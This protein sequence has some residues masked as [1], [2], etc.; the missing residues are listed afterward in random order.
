MSKL[1]KMSKGRNNNLDIIRLLAALGVIYSHAYPLCVGNYT[2][3]LAATLTRNRMSVG[4]IA[5]STFFILSGFLITK[6]FER[7]PHL[8]SYLKAR[9]FRIVPP[10]LIVILI[11]AFIIGPLCTSLPYKEYFRHTATWNYIKNL[12]MKFEYG[13]LPGV[14]ESHHNQGI[15]SSLWTLTYEVAFYIFIAIIGS[16]KLIKKKEYSIGFFILS[17]YL[18]LHKETIFTT[19]ILW[20]SPHFL[21]N[22]VYL[23]MFFTIGMIYY[24]YRDYIELTVRGFIIACFA[25]VL[26]LKLIEPN[27][28]FALFGSYIIICLAFNGKII[29]N[30]ISNYG[31]FSYGIYLFAFPIQQIYIMIFKGSIHP[32]LNFI[33]TTITVIPIA[34]I[35]WHFIEKKCL[36]LKN[37]NF[38]A[39]SQKLKKTTS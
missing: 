11:G 32:L 16:L 30:K 37:K 17:T 24:C 15:N 25:L 29:F 36:Q 28:A 26:G 13:T 18:Y 10:V 7:T 3:E 19:S 14:F 12:N 27:L 35:S 39:L 38:L 8:A 20:F 33:L 34:Y 1:S 21:K 5:V 22:F 23:G 31:D 9:F 4:S 6:S 2:G